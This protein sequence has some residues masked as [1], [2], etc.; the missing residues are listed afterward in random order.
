MLQLKRSLLVFV[1][2]S[3]FCGLVYPLAVT[4][5]AQ[6]FFPAQ[7][8]ASL[9]QKGN[10]VVGS[11][12]I[13]Q[14]FTRP[15]YFHGRP[16]ATDPPYD[17]SGSGGST[18]APSNKKLI[19]QA[20]IRVAQIRKDNRLSDTAFVPADLVLASASG[21][22]PHIAPASALL[23]ANRVAKERNIP[24]ALAEDL[25]QQCTEQPLLGVWGKERVNVLELNLALDKMKP[26]N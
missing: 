7:S 9:I 26:A 23:Q 13:G 20:Q 8:N 11:H 12:L 10:A 25:I 24:Q 22:D 5:V 19:K 16:S 18:L 14:S 3:I 2:L 21:L 17:A 6:I 15:E 1:W 4:G